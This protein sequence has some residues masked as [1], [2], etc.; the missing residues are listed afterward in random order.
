MGMPGTEIVANGSASDDVG[1]LNCGAK[2]T[3]LAM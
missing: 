1:W 2:I 3:V